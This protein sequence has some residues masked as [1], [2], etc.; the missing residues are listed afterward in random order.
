MDKKKIIEELEKIRRQNITTIVEGEKDRR[1]LQEL[2]IKRIFVL[3]KTG[4]S[5]YS[6]LESLINQINERPKSKRQIVILTDF[7]KKGKMLYEMI[8]KE[9]T[10]QRIKINNV[11]RARLLEQHV[12]HIEG[13]AAFLKEEL[14]EKEA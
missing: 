3:H 9:V 14:Q 1:A 12:S 11:L 13:L 10:R 8:K 7:D 4:V 2:G 5:I 6:M